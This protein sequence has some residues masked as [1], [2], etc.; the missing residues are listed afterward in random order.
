MET[1]SSLTRWGRECGMVAGP[2]SEQRWHTNCAT[3]TRTCA[4]PCCRGRTISPNRSRSISCRPRH[5]ILVSRRLPRAVR[6]R[7]P[8]V[9]ARYGH[10]AWRRG[11]GGAAPA[12]RVGPRR[13]H[14]A[15]CAPP[16]PPRHGELNAVLQAGRVERRVLPVAPAGLVGQQVA[17]YRQRLPNS[18]AAR[19][20]QASMSRAVATARCCAPSRSATARSVG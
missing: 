7:W 17:R 13:A 18:T 10:P 1:V 9:R 11:P 16:R 3:P 6:R 4:P 14:Q 12:G 2:S 15:P 5:P 19:M 8:S 20:C